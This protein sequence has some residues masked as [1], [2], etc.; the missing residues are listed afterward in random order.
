VLRLVQVALEFARSQ[1][2]ASVLAYA[3][4]DELS[5]VG[6]GAFQLRLSRAQMLFC[7]YTGRG[8]L[9]SV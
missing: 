7:G 8:S 1:A 4:S 5:F 3:T 9:T 2:Y 6:A